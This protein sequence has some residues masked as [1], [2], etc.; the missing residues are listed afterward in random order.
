[1]SEALARFKD[2][3]T[4]PP[5]E[6]PTLADFREG[7]VIGID[8]SLAN[9]GAVL[10]SC[11]KGR[12]YVHDSQTFRT[13][14]VGD[15]PEDT[16]LR[17]EQMRQMLL[18]HLGELVPHIPV[19]HEMPLP[20]RPGMKGSR[21]ESAWMAAGAVHAAAIDTGHPVSMF[22]AQHHRKITV[23]LPKADKIEYHAALM[24]WAV[25]L[26]IVGLNNV[27]NVDERDGLGIAL[28]HLLED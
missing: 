26:Q 20:I 3:K 24:A 5:W 10:L 23:N 18:T 16:L 28:T 8:Q 25:D 21:P 14:R 9:C 15:G 2:K 1:M 12:L 13:K 27:T 17:F 11:A 6:P 22:G 19:R 4:A 7:S